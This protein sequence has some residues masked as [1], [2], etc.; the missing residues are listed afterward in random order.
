MEPEQRLAAVAADYRRAV[1]EEQRRAGAVPEAERAFAAA[2]VEAGRAGVPV[3]QAEL[4]DLERRRQELQQARLEAE[5][6]G[7]PGLPAAAAAELA[8]VERRIAGVKVEVV[9]AEETA[10]RIAE[11]VQ[12][13]LN[14][15]LE[16]WEARVIEIQRDLNAAGQARQA[17]QAQ[18]NAGGGG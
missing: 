18:L 9:V 17:G 3:R 12:T 8:G 1:E 5:A 6:R 14:K 11:A 2:R 16:G 15:R 13:E 10:A 4:A 7:G